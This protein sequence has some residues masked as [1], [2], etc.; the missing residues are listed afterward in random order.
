MRWVLI[1]F[2]CLVGILII[3][4]VAIAALGISISAGPFRHQLADAMSRAIG[5]EVRF[6][7]PMEMQPTLTPSFRVG[8]ITLANP[9]GFSAPFFASLGQATL[10][11][12]LLALLRGEVH[13]RELS[14][15]GVKVHLERNGEA[16]VNWLI[17]LARKV[18]LPTQQPKASDGKPPLRLVAVDRIEFKELLVDYVGGP[19]LAPH[20]FTLNRLDGEGGDGQPLT[21][22]MQGSV[23]QS[24]PY[25]VSVTGG[26]L[27]GLT[28]DPKP[29]PIEFSLEFAGTV[30]RI[31]GSVRPDAVRTSAKLTFGMGA[32][33]LS[34]LERLLQVSLPPVGATGLSGQVIWENGV[35]NIRDLRGAM[36][37]TVLQGQLQVDVTQAVPRVNGEFTLPVFDVLPFRAAPD[38]KSGNDGDSIDLQ[39]LKE[40]HNAKQFEFRELAWVEADLALKVE[41]WIGMAGDVRESSLQVSVHGGVLKAPV[42]A[43]VAGVPLVGEI[44]LDG[45]APIPTFQ[46][47]M[48]AD[49]TELGQLARLLTG[50]DGVKGRLG[51]FLLRFAATG[52][53]LS[54]LVQSLQ[55]K[56]EVADADLTYGN[57]KGGKPVAVRLDRLDIE[58]PPGGR[59]NGKIR[60]S[61]LGERLTADFK[62]GDLATLSE[63]VQWPVEIVATGS[64]ATLSMHGKIAA[65]EKNSVTDIRIKLGSPRAGNVARWLGLSPKSTAPVA[66]SGRVRLESDEW[67]LSDLEVQL[68]KTKISGNFARVGIDRK[69]LVQAKLRVENL[70]L[71]ELESMLPP[72]KPGPSKPVIELP[73]LPQGI[74]LTDADVDVGVKRIALKPAAVTDITFVGKIRD[75]KMVASPF[76]A[77][78][79]DTVF[80]GAVALDMRGKTPQA[81]LWVAA[82]KPDIGRL[83]RTLRVVETLEVKADLLQ[84]Q[85]LAQGHRLGEMLEQ[86]AL[87]GSIEAGVLVLGDIN[88]KGGLRI[89]LSKGL[90]EAQPKQPV[91]VDLDGLI[92]KTPIKIRLASG[93]VSELLRASSYVPFSMTAEV[94]GTH[95][96]LSGK[97]SLPVSQ[98]AVELQLSVSGARVNSLDELAR[99]SLPHWGPYELQSRFRVSNA[100]YEMPGLALK[101][102]ASELKGNGSVMITGARPKIDLQ[103]AAP[104]IQLDDFKL[105]GWALAEKKPA[106]EE[107]KLTVEELRNKA[108][109]ATVR[110]EEMLSPATLKRQD[111]TLAVD[112]GEVLSGR[113]R[114]GSGSLRA[115]LNDG[116]L[117]LGP[118]EVTMPGGSAKLWL[119]YNPSTAGIALDAKVRVDRFD[120]G[121]LARRFKP[122]SDLQGMFSLHMDLKSQTPSLERAMQNGDGRLDFAVW[123]KNMKSGIF[124]L[125]A[126][127]LFVALI[128]AVDPALASKVNCA[129]G[130]F[131]LKQ[132][133]L[134]EDA[135]LI[136][137]SRMRVTGTGRVDFATESVSLKLSPKPKKPQFFSLAA[138]VEVNGKVTNPKIGVGAATVAGTAAKLFTSIITTPFERLFAKEIPRDGNDVCTDALRQPRSTGKL[139]AGGNFNDGLCGILFVCPPDFC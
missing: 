4:C 94:A 131:D 59:L 29:W 1:A 118:A 114:L 84:L 47:E 43:T 71:A 108:R 89:A 74:D 50:A 22:K 13:V 30:L 116:K 139:S 56:L 39:A 58:L 83:L 130:R 27:S 119:G 10:R 99:T 64:G 9:A 101:V 88:G 6:E 19:G 23:E 21:L 36:G 18:E 35:L 32:D 122:E 136:D 16:Q 68:G 3:G 44:N 113:D 80:S 25:T 79:A 92:D 8:G 96:G 110:T 77:K 34:N 66:L 69:P 134:T 73:I 93:S 67:R 61:L 103:L 128:P 75:G 28:G 38:T 7:G 15:Q 106:K 120:Y 14:A 115:T 97:V 72:P 11:L 137:T 5:R 90:I 81:T 123:P 12:D 124:D 132:G 40:K 37:R 31:A 126:V 111:A 33:D 102:G 121:V 51:H 54:A 63:E 112:V 48:G 26:A 65:P 20:V 135:I 107:K 125:W 98:R 105:D 53:N 86:S 41:R 87:V 24:F 104:R 138:P 129:V 57:I 85:L 55:M 45:A 52:K 60:G 17:Q 46:I 78:Y 76:S 117:A 70:E 49:K 2:G 91:H 109:E 127:N 95:V 62:G 133:V 100:G 82:Q 42:Q